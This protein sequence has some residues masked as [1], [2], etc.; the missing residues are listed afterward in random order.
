[1]KKY[2]MFLSLCLVVND[3]IFGKIIN[4]YEVEIKKVQQELLNLQGI[5]EKDISQTKGS[6]RLSF[7]RKKQW[8]KARIAWLK[9]YNVYYEL[10]ERLLKRFQSIAPDLYLEIDTIKDRKG[11]STDVY[12][13]LLPEQEMPVNVTATTNIARTKTDVDGYYSVYGDHTVSVKVTIGSQSL[14]LLAHEFGHIRYQVPHLAQYME[15]YKKQYNHSKFKATIMGHKT[16][17]PSG[18]QAYLNAK[19]F[20]KLYHN[21]IKRSRVQNYLNTGLQ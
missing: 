18:N 17:D 14:R 11:R 4:G 19:R 9:E 5:L 7:L 3:N 2:I 20:N 8:I 12:V 16:K 1:M 21:Y 13:K 10:T 15:Y 6:K